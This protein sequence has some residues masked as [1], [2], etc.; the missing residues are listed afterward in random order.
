[1][2]GILSYWSRGIEYR[3]FNTVMEDQ[4]GNKL[5]LQFHTGRWDARMK[6]HDAYKKVR[7]FPPPEEKRTLKRWMN[8]PVPL[9]TNKAPENLTDW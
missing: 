7:E 8:N 4:K 1:M 3:G 5:E 6:I 9:G 2:P